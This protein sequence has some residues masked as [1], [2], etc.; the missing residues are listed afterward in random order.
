M[1][2]RVL[3]TVLP[4]GAASDCAVQAT[5]APL[6]AP[7]ASCTSAGYAYAGV[8]SE[9]AGGGIKATVTALS[10]PQ[11]RQGHVAGW[12]GIGSPQ[13]GAGGPAEWL[14]TG[15]NALADGTSQLYV[16]VIGPGHPYTYTTVLSHVD[17]G[18]GYR[19][20]I[21][22]AG[23]ADTWQVRVNGAP[24]GEAVTLPGTRASRRWR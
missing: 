23:A 14:Q 8:V 12:I 2:R 5:A 20:A 9:R 4:L 18:V 13:A 16:E 11:V 21:V 17:A 19:I 7:A 22:K 15:L 10:R 3:L 1:L 6:A 24:A